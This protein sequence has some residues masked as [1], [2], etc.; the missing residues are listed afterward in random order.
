[1]S[2]TWPYF[3]NLLF[4]SDEMIPRTSCGNIP[5]SSGIDT[6]LD[7]SSVSTDIQQIES[8]ENVSTEQS[9][10]IGVLA[11][12]GSQSIHAPDDHTEKMLTN[13]KS[14]KKRRQN[15]EEKLLAVEREKLQFFKMKCGNSASTSLEQDSDYQFLLSLLPFLK[16]V[17]PNR[18]MIV[19]MKLQQVFIEEEKLSSGS[20]ILASTLSS[21][22]SYYTNS[23]SGDSY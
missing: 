8:E 19:R 20:S 6:V 2:S 12:P 16:N 11:E 7:D 14:T 1:M 21:V 15:I 3:Q 18:K 17:N 4:L 5:G 22:R 9:C 10:E 13:K 23:G